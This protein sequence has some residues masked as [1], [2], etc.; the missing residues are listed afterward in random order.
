MMFNWV[1]RKLKQIFK[2]QK[3]LNSNNSLKLEKAEAITLE[4]GFVKLHKYGYLQMGII[5]QNT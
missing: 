4:N 5:H 1:K 3:I 2:I